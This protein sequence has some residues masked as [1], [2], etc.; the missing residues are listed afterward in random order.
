MAIRPA[1]LFNWRAETHLII[2]QTRQAAEN[3]DCDLNGLPA[4]R[5]IFE[6]LLSQ[7]QSVTGTV[8]IHPLMQPKTLTNGNLY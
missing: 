4:T 1:W 2:Y 3:I 8:I 6:P 5:I 7:N